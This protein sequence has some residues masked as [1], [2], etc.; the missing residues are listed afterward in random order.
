MDAELL[1][2][3][4]KYLPL[5]R[6]R[7]DALKKAQQALGENKLDPE[8]RQQAVQKAHQLAGS[9][10]MFGHMDGTDAARKFEILMDASA[11]IADGQAAEL[12]DAVAVLARIVH[13]DK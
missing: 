1:A 13:D 12:N 8:L 6:E 5:M 7:V 9:L 11:P 2:M 10:G 3:W 4:Q